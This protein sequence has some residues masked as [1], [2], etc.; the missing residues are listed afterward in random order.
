MTSEHS[1][2]VILGTVECSRDGEGDGFGDGNGVGS[3]PIL[4]RFTSRHSSGQ[5]VGQ[6]ISVGKGRVLQSSRPKELQVGG[7]LPSSISQHDVGHS[8][9]R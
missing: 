2:G 4:S 6:E 8:S 1:E 3:Q 9:I 7:R 5:H